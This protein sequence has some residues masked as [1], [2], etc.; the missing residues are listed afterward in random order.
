MRV[1]GQPDLDWTF[2]DCKV[3][4]ERRAEPRS[5]IRSGGALFLWNKI[6][7]HAEADAARR[8]FDIDLDRYHDKLRTEGWS[9]ERYGRDDQ[10]QS[11]RP[12]G[13]ANRGQRM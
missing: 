8:G 6:E 10:S 3:T 7:D 12:A 4:S 2:A 5:C 13:C 11:Y 1:R 9:L